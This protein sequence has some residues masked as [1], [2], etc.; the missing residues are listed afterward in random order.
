MSSSKSTALGIQF[1]PMDTHAMR[2][3]L[4]LRVSQVEVFAETSL[5]TH[6]K[7]CILVY[8]NYTSVMLN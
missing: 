1:Q 8:V 7:W 2:Q 3:G 5:T 6:L 4:R